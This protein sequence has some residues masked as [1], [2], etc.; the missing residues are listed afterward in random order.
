MLAHDRSFRFLNRQ[1]LP[2]LARALLGLVA[3]LFAC[4]TGASP[5]RAQ[6]GDPP[7]DNQPPAQSTNARSVGDD[8]TLSPYWAPN[9]QR[10]SSY[11]GALA[12]AYG[13]DPDFIAAVIKH[14]SHGDEGVI[15]YM[16]AVGLMGVMPSGPGLEW[17]PTSS[18]LL[19]PATNL[20]WGMTILSYIVQQSGGD[21]Y[22]AL[23]AYN[24]GWKQ[25]N[26]RVPRE[27]AARVLDSYARAVVARNGMSPDSATQW[28]IAIQIRSGNVPT[29]PLLILGT[30]PLSDLR[31]F[32]EHTVYQYADVDGHVYHIRGYAV[33]VGL[34]DL[35][36]YTSP[37]SADAQ[38]L[39]PALLSRLGEKGAKGAFGN[40]KVLLTCLP[41]L[42]RLRGAINTRWFAPSDCPAAGR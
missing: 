1:N 28:T 22:S 8:M 14:E 25:V 10:W 17:R 35:V 2:G 3:A 18:E 39:E 36:P 19:T 23:A 32:A 41:S 5:T 30:K 33:P 12:D 26:S 20:R 24:G 9:I 13:F 38:T 29:E 42:T 11:I 15:S 31:L 6:S 27:Y 40:D 21:L 34:T 16:G 37:S 4:L 7:L